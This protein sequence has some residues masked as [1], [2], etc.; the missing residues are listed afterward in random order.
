VADADEAVK[1]YPDHVWWVKRFGISCGALVVAG[2]ITGVAD[3][4]GISYSVVTAFFLG[5][6]VVFFVVNARWFVEDW[7][8]EKRRQAAVRALRNGERHDQPVLDTNRS[9]RGGRGRYAIWFGVAVVSCGIPL[10]AV[11][12]S[13]H[14]VVLRDVGLVLIVV[15]LVVMAIVLPGLSAKHRPGSG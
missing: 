7:R 3:A 5:T 9:T 8:R 14:L 15:E 1:P 4:V 12:A 10:I 6:M 13:M 11:G 2:V